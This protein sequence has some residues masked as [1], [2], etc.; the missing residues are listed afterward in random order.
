MRN[1][2][3]TNPYI[4]DFRERGDRRSFGP[5]TQFPFLDSNDKLVVNDRRS[6]P[7]RRIANI[8]VKGHFLH[9]NRNY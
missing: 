6:K 3:K 2:F 9:I 7:D 5:A 1:L 8:Q 4:L